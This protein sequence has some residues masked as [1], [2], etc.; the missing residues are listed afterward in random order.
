MSSPGFVYEV[1]GH[2]LAGAA[3]LGVVL[4]V[5]TRRRRLRRSMKRGGM[6][7]WVILT[8]G[9]FSIALNVLW[10]VSLFVLGRDSPASLQD[11]ASEY[12]SLISLSIII[13]LLLGLRVIAERRETRP[14][15]ILAIGAH[16]DDIEI[17]CG[18]SMAKFHDLGDVSAGVVMTMGEK[19]GDS[20]VRPE[21]AF[22]GAQFLGLD[23]VKVLD[24]P[25]TRLQEHSQEIIA[26]IESAI[27]EFQPDFILTHSAHDIHQDHVAVHQAT[28][29]AARTQRTILCYESPSVTQEFVPTLFIDVA[30]YIEVKVESIK[31]HWDQRN[32]PYVQPERVKGV[33]VFRGGQ[34]KTRFAEAFEVVRATLWSIE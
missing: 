8:I 11:V 18:A 21:E 32:K 28:L 24:F 16:P 7:Y 27:R 1:I 23:H 15:R 26:A 10:M 19:G 9:T 4:Y 25:D 12:V 14:R 30:Q 3:L 17:A 2:S 34:A 33:A 22:S 31:E 5:G 29:R 20:S 13:V 6:L